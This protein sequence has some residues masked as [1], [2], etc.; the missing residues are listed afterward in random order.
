MGKKPLDIIAIVDIYQI[1][2]KKTKSISV[3]LIA[4]CNHDVCPG[5]LAILKKIC[6]FWKYT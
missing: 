2:E 6:F 5:M 1:A 4:H 3:M